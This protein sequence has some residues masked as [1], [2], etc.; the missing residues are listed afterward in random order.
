MVEDRKEIIQQMISDVGSENVLYYTET[1]NGFSKANLEDFLDDYASIK[2]IHLKNTTYE[3]GSKYRDICLKL[4]ITLIFSTQ[5]SKGDSGLMY[6]P[7]I[8]IC[9]ENKSEKETI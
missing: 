6:C 9:K 7:Y 5:K 4:K 3:I 1:P 8:A 2:L